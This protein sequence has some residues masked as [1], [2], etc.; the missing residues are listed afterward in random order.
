[1]RA[2]AQLL[3]A[4]ACAFLPAVVAAAT[5]TVN[6]TDDAVDAVPMDGVCATASGACTL[7]AA[8]MEANA[9]PGADTI[10][11]PAGTYAL[12]LAGRDED[13]AAT[14]DLDINDDVTIQGAGSA[15][16]ILDGNGL[17]R[18]FDNLAG[19]TIS[20][21]TIRNGNPGSGPTGHHGGAIFNGDLL[22]LSDVVITGNT[23]EMAGAGIAN[24]GTLTI[25]NVTLSGNT[26]GTTGGGLDNAG[27]AALTNVTVS[28]NSASQGGGIA[29]TGDELDLTNVTVSGNTAAASGG[30]L[31]NGF[32]ASLTNVT[33]V[34]NSAPV[35]GGI[36]D[37]GAT[38]L[39]NTIVA[40][41]AGGDCGGPT[42]PTSAGHNLE[43]QSS[44]ALAGPGDLTETDPRVGPLEANGG[45]TATHALFPDSPAIDAGGDC[46][47]PAV[48]QRG[49]E[50]PMDGNG[51]GVAACDIGAYEA[52][53]PGCPIA[54]T[55]PS[56][57]CRL[58]ALLTTVRG[59]GR[60]GA[61]RDRLEHR[62]AD[63][64]T[65]LDGAEMALRAGQAR[66]A[67]RMTR[68][69]LARMAAIVRLVRSRPARAA[70]PPDTLDGLRGDAESV[71][72]DLSI[73]RRLL[74]A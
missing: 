45:P 59:E 60:P 66:A 51:D 14:G 65:R 74:N 10:V 2:R 31:E 1:M 57:A 13:D 46:P 49:R 37:V 5:F 15:N 43:G 26:A 73:L 3:T 41:N 27:G 18:F 36:D 20:G 62:L 48:D 70:F 24:I 35:A 58:D 6:T 33:V 7:R 8:I 54:P 72:R 42:P 61:V 56:I 63:A 38:T 29:S 40:G 4:V 21:V 34:A 12:T 55:F 67:R 52:P 17:D 53:P 50:R 44:C 30:G 16:T 19:T 22:T 11:V 69:T 68:E 28:G 25:T 23:A 47:P 39:R 64:R 71:R 9:L 32:V